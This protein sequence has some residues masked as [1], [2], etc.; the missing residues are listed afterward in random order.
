MPTLPVEE[1]KPV[2][3]SESNDSDKETAEQKIARLEKEAGKYRR[4]Y[5]KK[6]KETPKGEFVTREEL[7]KREERQAVK[8]ATTALESDPDDFKSQKAEIKE[9]WNEIMKYF[10]VD[11]RSDADVIEEGIYDAFAVWKRRTNGVV[12]SDTAIA[13]NLSTSTGKGGASPNQVP[14]HRT[15]FP[16]PQSVEE[17]YPKKN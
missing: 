2:T 6:T 5:E 7:Y 9:N 16:K 17:W 8:N 1:E 4:L 14:A 12:K 15:F 13:A 11:N 3:Q 10:R